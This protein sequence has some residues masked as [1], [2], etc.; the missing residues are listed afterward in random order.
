MMKQPSQGRPIFRF[1]AGFLGL[2]MLIV[3]VMS[4]LECFKGN[5]GLGFPFIG[6]SIAAGIP[7]TRFALTGKYFSR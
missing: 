6:L 5:W 4:V 7:M 3:L 1:L 2:F